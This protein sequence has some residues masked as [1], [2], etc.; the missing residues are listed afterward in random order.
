MRTEDEGI[1]VGPGAGKALPNPIGGRMVVKVRDEDTGGGYSIHDNTIP[2]GSPG[3]RPHIH[4]YHDEAFYVLEGELTMRVGPRKFTA[5]AGSFVVVPRGA[6]TSPRTRGRSRPECC[7]SSPPQGWTGFSKRQPKGACR[8]RQPRQIRRSRRS[9]RP[10]PRSTATSSR[11]SRQSRSA[12]FSTLRPSGF[13]SQHGASR[14]SARSGFASACQHVALASPGDLSAFQLF[15]SGAG[16]RP[17]TGINHFEN[18][19]SS[20]LLPGWIKT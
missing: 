5:P 15:V 3:P 20:A 11:S 14:L 4:R 6:S 9:S 12:H 8:C 19:C 7:S 1:F 17:P 13:A 2:S 18:C 16:S 10:F